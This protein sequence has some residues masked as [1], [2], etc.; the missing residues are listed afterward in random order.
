MSLKKLRRSDYHVAWIAPVSDLELLPSR[1]MLDEEHEAPDYDTEYDD[2]IYTCGSMAGHNVVI[3][4]CPPGL[5]GNINA[6]R[7]T[8][9]MFKTFSSIRM[10]LLVGIGGGIPRTHQS[11]DPTENIH[12]GDVVVG[13]PGDGRAACV[14]YDSGKFRTDGRFEIIGT[15][16]RP[17]RVLLNALA[18][19]ASDHDMDRATFHKHHERLFALQKHKRKF[20]FPGLDQD[21][22]FQSTY[23]HQGHHNDK[24]ATCDVEKLVDRPA[25]NEEH[26]ATFIFHRGRIATG[27]A[28]IKD[29]ERRDQIREQCDGAICVEMEAAGVDA[30]RSCL[31]IR[32]ISDY[33][34]S[35]KSDAWRSFA[36]GNA[37]VF[38][39]ELLSKV[40]PS[41]VTSL[42]A[43]DEP[44]HHFMVPFGRNKR[45]VGREEELDWLLMRIPPTAYEDDCQRTVIEGLGGM[46]KTQLVIEATYRVRQEH[47]GCSVFWV[48]VTSQTA[49]EQAYNELG[50]T[51]GLKGI[52]DDHADV[53]MLVKTALSRDD[54][55]NWL[56][57]VDN[58]DDRK[59]LFKGVDLMSYL[60][61]SRK[62]S[63]L[64][65][66]RNHQIAVR[67][68]GHGEVMK[69]HELKKLHASQLLVQGLE[70]P[71]I[72]DQKDIADLLAYLAY[73]PLAI[74]QAAAYMA[75]NTNITVAT[76]LSYCTSSEK[77]LIE[78]LSK[79]F[80]YQDQYEANQNPLATTWLISF[81]HVSRD[82]PPAIEC[83]KYICHLAEK[84][85]PLALLPLG[86][87]AMVRDEAV[88]ILKA[89]AFIT[90][91]KTPG[92]FD[93]HRLVRLALHNWLQKQRL[94]RSEATK[95]IAILAWQVGPR[96]YIDLSLMRAYFLHAETIL[97]FHKL[98]MDSEALCWVW[99][100]LAETAMTLGD[101]ARAEGSYRQAL[102]LSRSL[103]GFGGKNAL[104]LQ[105]RLAFILAFQSKFE[106]AE[107]RLRE[108]LS[109]R[110][111]S[112]GLEH[113]ETVSSLFQLAKVLE[114]SG[115]YTASIKLLRQTLILTKRRLGPNDPET[116]E[117]ILHLA[118][119][120]AELG[121]VS[122]AKQLILSFSG[123]EI[124]HVPDSY[125]TFK[126]V[127]KLVRT[128]NIAGEH[129]S[130]E[131]MQRLHIELLETSWQSQPHRLF[132][133][134]S[135]LRSILVSRGK[136]GEA[137]T[138]CRQM[139][140]L[141]LETFGQNSDYVYESQCELANTLDLQGKYEEAKQMYQEAVTSCRVLYGTTNP[142]ILSCMEELVM[143]LVK[144]CD[145]TGAEISSIRRLLEILRASGRPQ[146]AQELVLQTLK[147]LE[148]DFV[149]EYPHQGLFSSGSMIVIAEA[150]AGLECLLP[151]HRSAMQTTNNK[152]L[153]AHYGHTLE[154]FF[155]ELPNQLLYGA[156]EMAVHFLQKRRNCSI[157]AGM[158]IKIAQANEASKQLLVELPFGGSSLQV[159]QLLLEDDRLPGDDVEN[160]G[161]DL[162]ESAWED[163]D[164]DQPP[165]SKSGAELTDAGPS[166]DTTIPDP[167][168]A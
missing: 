145:W 110:R 26:V 143:V 165:F 119:L 127:E 5:T 157:L 59:L 54:A 88:G 11:D 35:H 111:K 80:D 135:T 64:F 87:D 89:Y 167:P 94:E 51:I 77:P 137:E 105:D 27:H 85:I 56:L 122:E 126:N 23:P 91:R 128:M 69:L 78:L 168:D 138:A 43:K 152:R 109:L 141:S 130:A 14:P 60:P 33:A 132:S 68:G 13:W 42:L 120:F 57:V 73:L 48:P 25:R 158:I 114:M 61:F 1:L 32:G 161:S 20:T 147:I 151:L 163:D 106:E 123:R 46:G 28:V 41:Q 22:L 156:R 140:S 112:Q 10:A 18:K 76:Y 129:A 17:D 8:G 66:T 149:L 24:C 125:V 19:L 164:I 49:F 9:S 139:L 95:A 39:R 63:I 12:L 155:S 150:F 97:G 101:Y 100:T 81:E 166:S 160:Y 34:D 108:I 154:I 83:L 153:I 75:A 44:K 107:V 3:A 90:E 52:E 74:R 50:R 40:P 29:A 162:S 96:W 148:E 53:K 67:L 115:K 21:R 6:G 142:T 93:M 103:W 134:L 7:V 62:G 117:H 136:Y 146:E 116:L 47:P 124:A 31:V 72:T 36:A 45:F 159:D 84:D 113:P 79:G 2:N 4:T 118:N 86:E 58:A 70:A 71:Q 133:G 15:I 65:T 104:F 98:C 92:R 131:E 82:K 144:L 102:L 30:S 37:A 121:R 99:T 55:G 16:D 38:A